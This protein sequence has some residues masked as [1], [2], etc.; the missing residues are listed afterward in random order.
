MAQEELDLDTPTQA[1]TRAEAEAQAGVLR[2]TLQRHN[3]LYYVEAKPEIS[4]GEYD[5][6][7]R[8]L[9]ALEEAYPDLV[10]PDSPTQRVGAEPRDDLPTISH[11]AP[12]LSLD[13]TKEE[14]DLV[15]FDERVRKAVGDPVQYLVEPKLDGASV[16]LV[17]EEGVLVRAVTRG[18]GQEGEGVTENVRTISSVPLRLRDEVRPVPPFLAIRGEVLMYLSAFRALNEKLVEEGSD[19]FANPRNASAGALRQLD[20]RITAQRPLDLL[21][22]DVLSV[23][24][25]EFSEDREIV[26]ALGDWGFRVP[27][28][29]ALLDNVDGIL[30]Y[31]QAFIR[32][33]DDLDYEIDGIVIKLNDL[34]SRVTMGST[35]RH[36]RWALAFKFEPRKEVTRI[37]RIAVSVG[38]TGVVTPVALLLPVE[39][40]GVTV[41]RASLH[42]REE[43]DRKDVR[44]GDLVRIQRA[45]DVIPQV[46]G[47]VEEA[48]K[49]RGP[50]FQMPSKCPS[51]GT[52]VVERGPFTVCPNQFGCPAQLKGRIMHFGSRGALDIE[53]LGEET[54]ALLVQEGL[55]KGLADLF[56]LKAGDIMDLPGFAEKSAE[57]LV[58]GIHNRKR[59]ELRRFLHGLGIPEVG[60]AVARDLASHFGG[61]QAIRNADREALEAVDG[62]G[63]KMSEVIHGFF[64]EDHNSK[65]I[66]E[67]L[68]KGM[69]LIAPSAARGEGGSMAGKKFVFTGGMESLSRPEAKKLVEAA[70]AKT[71]SS[72]SA[73]TNYVVAGENAGS[74][75]VRA[76]ELGVKVLSEEQ[77]LELMD[78]VNP[79][80][81][82]GEG[83]VG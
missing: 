83:V 81:E 30:E 24:E 17:Y 60:E 50:A 68:S 23:T 32:D 67:V 59:V 21:A 54:A 55:V 10:T 80:D 44:E 29:V 22:F 6:L 78:E 51:C 76:Q 62:I 34:A 57:N 82:G 49:E 47:R 19:P 2:R 11:T 38:R 31:H 9:K 40:G 35:S 28:R 46:L 66:D 45:G 8:R 18:N 75:L 5:T 37:H 72:V 70:G 20:P 63:P 33:R 58:Q 56:D 71:V 3:Y 36:P 12:M 1:L 53:G 64:H 16:E 65:A 77:F 14:E 73:S 26:E 42:N 13:S 48:G 41:S 79:E 39:V 7:F 27:E 61:F 4:D 52:E 15:R 69:D 43:V 74:K 25:V